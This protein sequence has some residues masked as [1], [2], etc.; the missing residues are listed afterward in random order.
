MRE[1][2]ESMAF[3]GW[4][5]E[6]LEF[7]E[8]LEADNSKAF[9]QRHKETYE[10]IVRAPM[11]DLLAELAPEWGEGRIFRPYRDV[12]FSPD[13]T[14]YKTNIA[15]ELGGGYV[16]LTASGLGAGAGMW[17]MAPDQLERYREAVD[18]DR[19]GAKLETI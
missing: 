18:A 15:A 9:W 13:K 16:Q 17:E 5:V 3:R 1:G 4:P 14:P 12:R 6:A 2:F 7:Y 8:A 10:T 11:E 19:T